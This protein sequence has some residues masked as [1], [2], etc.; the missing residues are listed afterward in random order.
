M[1]IARRIYTLSGMMLLVGFSGCCSTRAPITVVS[2]HHVNRLVGTWEIPPNNVRF[3]ISGR[4]GRY[5]IEGI[6]TSDRER[7]CFSDMRWDGQRLTGTTIMRSTHWRVPRS[8][9]LRGR[10]T[11]RGPYLGASRGKRDDTWRRSYPND[12]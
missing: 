1:S 8:L 11:L 12:I 5:F 3:T 7:F 10:D 2:P 6:D 4:G 9:A